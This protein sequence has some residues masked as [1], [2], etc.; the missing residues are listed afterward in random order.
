[1]FCVKYLNFEKVHLIEIEYL[2]GEIRV[3]IYFIL[4]EKRFRASIAQWCV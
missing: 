3:Q 1:M 2:T 4:N